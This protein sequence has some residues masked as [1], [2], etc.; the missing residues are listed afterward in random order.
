MFLEHATRVTGATGEAEVVARTAART[1]STRARSQDDVSLYT[2]TYQKV[3]F[4]WACIPRR[5]LMLHC[6]VCKIGPKVVI[7]SCPDLLLTE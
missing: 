4:S 2:Q 1:P 6:Q 3:Q 5:N 7:W